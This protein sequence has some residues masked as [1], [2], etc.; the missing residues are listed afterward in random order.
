MKKRKEGCEEETSVKDPVKGSEMRGER[1]N[2]REGREKRKEEVVVLPVS[3]I[4]PCC[5]WRRLARFFVFVFYV[6]MF[7]YTVCLL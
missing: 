1:I 6:C 7:L 5:M 3:Q 2:G 4:R